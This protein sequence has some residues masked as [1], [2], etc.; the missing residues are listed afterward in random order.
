VNCK[1]HGIEV[2]GCSNWTG[3]DPM[4]I[5]SKC[6]EIGSFGVLGEKTHA[7][8]QADKSTPIKHRYTGIKRGSKGVILMSAKRFLPYFGESGGNRG[9]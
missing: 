6:V 2:T 1:R 5:C 4:E 9:K 7:G 3:D 8:G